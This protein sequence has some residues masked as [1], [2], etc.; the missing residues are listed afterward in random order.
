MTHLGLQIG[1][2]FDERFGIILEL[3][4]VNLQLVDL[5]EGISVRR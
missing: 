3:G 4:V 1:V 5:Q 2:D